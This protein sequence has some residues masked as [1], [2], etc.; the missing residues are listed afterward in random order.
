MCR[1][2]ILPATLLGAPVRCQNLE[3]HSVP[4]LDL[5]RETG[6]SGPSTL[7]EARRVIL[8]R[9]RHRFL[10]DLATNVPPIDRFV[11]FTNTRSVSS[12]D[13]ESTW[14]SWIVV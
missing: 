7:N 2:V 1:P 13:A 8:A 11:D 4:A 10:L 9:A 6:A 5:L 3:A 12:D 14:T